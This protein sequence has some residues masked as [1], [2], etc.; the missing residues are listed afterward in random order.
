MKHENII[1]PIASGTVKLFGG[2][3]ILRTPSLIRANPDRGEEQGNFQEE[4]KGF[5]QL[6]DKTHRRMMVKQETNSDPFQKTTFTVFTWNPESNCACREKPH[7]TEIHR[8]DQ[9]YIFFKDGRNY[10][11]V[12]TVNKTG[13]RTQKLAEQVPNTLPDGMSVLL[14]HV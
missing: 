4:S 6:H 9:N 5:L 14:Y 1:F 10:K 11:S 12:H 13:E 7:S 8:R 3:Q 2:D